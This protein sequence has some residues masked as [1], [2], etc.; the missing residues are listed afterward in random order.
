MSIKISI[1]KPMKTLYKDYIASKI[2]SKDQINHQISILINDIKRMKNKLFH[3]SKTN[4]NLALYHYECGN[5]S[6]AILRL[7]M[8]KF[9]KIDIPEIDY[10]LGC[11]YF[12]KLEYK[13]AKFYFDQYIK[14]Q[15]KSFFNEVNYCEKMIAGQYDEIDEVP[16]FFITHKLD[17]AFW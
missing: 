8:L 10:Y 7:K 13:A 5:I 17:K 15:D 12:E 6:D 4:Y 14:L 3:L 16:D 1:I 2:L 9:F 11:C